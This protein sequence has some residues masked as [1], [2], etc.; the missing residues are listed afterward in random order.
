MRKAF[1]F[2]NSY[3]T[4]FKEL[5]DKDKL[6]FI[7][8]LLEK[9]FEGKEPN[10]IGQAKFA[11]LSQKHSIDS[12]VLGYETKTKEKLTPTVGGRQ[13]GGVGASVQEKGKEKGKVELTNHYFKTDALFEKIKF[14]EAFPEWSKEK[15]AY[16]YDNALTWSNEGNMKKDWKATIRGWA[17]RD[18]KLGKLKFDVKST[19]VDLGGLI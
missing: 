10:L 19:Y 9:Q 14:K 4:V 15:L 17:S 5:S 2:Y 8:A 13:G 11:Y 12:Q 7:T 6:A 16:Y 18:E 3:F 1:N